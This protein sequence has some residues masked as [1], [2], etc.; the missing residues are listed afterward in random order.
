MN[1]S[2]KKVSGVAIAF[3]VLAFV[4]C[5]AVPVIYHNIYNS[6]VPYYMEQTMGEYLGHLGFWGLFI[7]EVPAIILAV[8]GYIFLK[9]GPKED[10]KRVIIQQTTPASS[11]DEIKKYKNCLMMV[12]LPKKNLKKRR[13]R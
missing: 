10:N 7:L 5:I 6:N 4:C 2:N 13:N 9:K 1:N 3:F 12:L 8:I 11:A